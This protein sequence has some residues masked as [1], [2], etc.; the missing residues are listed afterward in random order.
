[1][2][3]IEKT[4]WN[5]T[6]SGYHGGNDEV[7]FNGGDNIYRTTDVSN[8]SSLYVLSTIKPW[9][10]DV[11]IEGNEKIHLQYQINGILYNW[12]DIKTWDFEQLP[13]TNDIAYLPQE[14]DNNT[15][16][17]IRYWNDGDEPSSDRVYIQEIILGFGVYTDP[18]EDVI[19]IVVGVI[20]GICCIPCLIIICVRSI[21]R[22][23]KQKND[24]RA[25]LE[26]QSRQKMANRNEIDEIEMQ[27]AKNREA[28]KREKIVSIE[29]YT[30]NEHAKSTEIVKDTKD[31]DADEE[32][33]MI[34]RE[35]TLSYSAAHC[36]ICL[37]VLLLNEACRLNCGHKFHTHCIEEYN[38]TN[39]IC[40][41]CRKTIVFNM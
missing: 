8:Y 17:T 12:I 39:G 36:V 1:M 5:G 10:D 37:D 16:L 20:A 25:R 7:R 33:E 28:V 27:K 21:K 2:G 3:N 13:T 35:G 6:Y 19:Y 22:K 11:T 24:R 18:T 40:P 9:F 15:A 38:E 23:R 34:E 41:L 14:V 32:D 26:L 30:G 29:N 31:V 4:G